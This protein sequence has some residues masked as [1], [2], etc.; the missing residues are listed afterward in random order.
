MKEI[1]IKA[2]TTEGR[3]LNT[4]EIDQ[5]DTI[6]IL[7][8]MNEEDKTVAYVV[9][10][11]LPQIALLV[12]KLVECFEK[13]GRLIYMGAG[14]SGRIGLMDAVEC[15]PTFSCSYEMVQCLMAGGDSAMVRAIE[16]AEDNREMAVEQLKAINLSANDCVIGI[17]ASGRTPYTV[18]GVEYA[19]SIGCVTGCITTS[20]HSILAKI[21]KYPVETIT[22]PEVLMGSTRLKSGTAQK[23]ICNMITTSSMIRL[24]RVYSNLLIDMRPTNDKLVERSKNIIIEGLGVSGE[25][26]EKLLNKYGTIKY[27]MFSGI[28]GIEDIAEIKKIFDRNQGNMRKALQEVKN[29]L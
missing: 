1:N 25:V 16:G 29:N 23:L 21:A 15:Y 11:A 4:L 24:G 12:D 7:K 9:E 17:A 20:K 19:N 22:G 10:Q 5:L 26:A 18:A 3:N 8:K 14:T 13:G 28:T 6:G 27:A 2:I